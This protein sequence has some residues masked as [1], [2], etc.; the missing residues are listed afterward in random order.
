MTDI[1]LALP[2]QQR[3]RKRRIVKTLQRFN[4][5]VQTL[6]DLRD[7]VDGR[8][9]ISDIREL[10][11]DDLLGREPV[12]PDR[13]LLGRTVVNRRVLVSGAGGS[14][15]SELCRQILQ[16]GPSKLVLVESNEYALY[17]IERSLH[18]WSR[19][20]EAA[21]EIVAVLCSVQDEVRL[22]EV[23]EEH[24]PET[25]F[26][27]AA[28]K[29]VPLV[30]T[31]PIEGIRNNILGTQQIALAAER[32]GVGHFILVSTDKAVRPTN[33]MGATKR[34]AELV[35]QA[36]ADKPA[37]TTRYAIVRFGNVL[38]SSGSVVP[39]FR[40]QIAQGGPITLTHREVTRYFMTIPEAALLV[41]QAAGLA[42]SGEVF[43]LDMGEPVKIRDLAETM[44]RLSGLTVRDDRHP[45][46]DIEIR[47]IGM[48]PGE[49]LIEE[50]LIGENPQPTEHPRIMMAK[51][52]FIPADR[53]DPL[54]AELLAERRPG[55]ALRLLKK[56]VP[57]FAHA[58]L[59]AVSARAAEAQEPA[60]EPD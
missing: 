20:H 21:V 23:F 42:K 39:L 12:A 17:A 5:H 33:V 47:E 49:K 15:G 14:I 2:S 30:E 6:P 53:L 7:I 45:D 54:L 50:L 35:I 55:P 60:F 34:G 24:S 56:L 31:N 13:V 1:L 11:L 18:L 48:R 36:L 22:A 26:H 29:H 40:A 44:V 27:A 52:D 19:E 9:S 46:G 3:A 32:A 8:V 10:E 25:V 59:G 57:Q 16:I 28:F 38:G 41:I 43:V 51:E 37:I 4:V 58:P